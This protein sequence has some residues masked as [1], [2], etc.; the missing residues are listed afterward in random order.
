MIHLPLSADRSTAASI[1][2]AIAVIFASLIIPHT[3]KQVAQY[4]AESPAAS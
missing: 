1:E 2:A 4:I 3:F